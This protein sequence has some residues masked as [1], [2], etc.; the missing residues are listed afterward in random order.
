MTL[1]ADRSPRVR[2]AVAQNPAAPPD[3]LHVL[4][5]DRHYQVRFAVT[6][7]PN[8]HA[9][10]IALASP[11][12][13]V[14]EMV[15]HRGDLSSTDIE[16][17]MRDPAHQ[18]RE[19]LAQWSKDPEVLARLARDEHPSV[20]AESVLNQHLS[21]EDTEMLAAD[22]IARVRA[23]AA[24]SRR[25]DPATLTRLASDR[26]ANVRWHVLVFNPE[27][28]DLAALI[29]EDTDELNA[30]QAQSQLTDP[31]EFPRSLEELD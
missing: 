15:A 11:I 14:R 25:L 7:N 6:E 4:V 26:S 29:A 19:Q 5:E 20:R 21:R 9:I 31:R 12:R 13:D 16:A 3:L 8:R 30:G 1:A 2:A 10:A 24:S 28:L 22:R 18:V 23:V 17:L 27:R